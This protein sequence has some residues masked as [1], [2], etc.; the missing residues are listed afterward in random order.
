M[1]KKIVVAVVVT[2]IAA[3]THVDYRAQTKSMEAALLDGV[4]KV[5]LEDGIDATEASLI[6]RAF[7]TFCS[8]STAFHLGSPAYLD[9]KWVAAVFVGDI[10]PILSTN[11][12]VLDSRSG[13]IKFSEAAL[14]RPDV[15][16]YK[17]IVSR[18]VETKG[19]SSAFPK[20]NRS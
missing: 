3:C 12:L 9:G 1:R 17:D 13:D 19:N 4:N 6:V 11:S 2:W 8:R 15:R 16:N 20:E 10:A 18:C 5:V 14:T 7:E